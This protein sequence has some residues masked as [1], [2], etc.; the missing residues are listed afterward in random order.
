MPG[1]EALGRAE[2]GA[3]V[4][5]LLGFAPEERSAVQGS[6]DHSYFLHPVLLFP[7]AVALPGDAVLL[8]PPE[9]CCQGMVVGCSDLWVET[10]GCWP[11]PPCS[12]P[13]CA[14]TLLPPP[15]LPH[16]WGFASSVPQ[17]RQTEIVLK[18][19]KDLC[20]RCVLS[21]SLV[22]NNVQNA[23]GKNYLRLNGFS[24]VHME[25]ALWRLPAAL[26]TQTMQFTGLL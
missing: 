15:A 2:F 19:S 11:H 9:G 3:E 6:Q 20:S 14:A 5:M 1:E 22:Y 25:N 16:P 4:G 8:Q 12:R 18:T 7:S 23:Y 17:S 10:I 13:L 21:R 24:S 26:R